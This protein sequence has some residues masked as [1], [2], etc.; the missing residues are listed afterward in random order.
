MFVGTWPLVRASWKHSRST[1]LSWASVVM[2]LSLLGVGFYDVLFPDP[3][4]VESMQGAVDTNPAL[5]LVMGPVGDLSSTDGLGAWLTVGLGAFF[6]GIG[7]ALLTV[8]SSRGQEDDGQAE[9]FAS[10]V[11]GRGARL[12]S[13]IVIGTGG[14]L[15]A[16]L[17]TAIVATVSGGTVETQLLVGA[18][19]TVT[20]WI[21]TA[22]AAVAAQLGSEK[23]TANTLALGVLSALYVLRGFCYSLDLPEWTIWAN[24]L[25]WMGQTEPVTDNIWWPLLLG[26]AFASLLVGIALFLQSRRDF[27]AGALAPKPGPNH[28]KI[29]G[30]GALTWRLNRSNVITWIGVLVVLGVMFGYF[31]AD[32]ADTLGKN[33]AVQQ[34]LASGTASQDDFN[35]QVLVTELTI[36]GV[37]A[38]IPGAQM[39]FKLRLEE[40]AYRIEPVLA[41][42]LSRLRLFSSSLALAMLSTALHLG[43]AGVLISLVSRASGTD[44][45]MRDV[46]AQTA[47]TLPAVWFFVA[48]AAFFVGVWPRGR[49]I[50]W[51]AIMASFL[52]TVLGP[53]LQ[54]SDWVLSWSPFHHVPSV[55][56]ADP[57]WTGLIILSAVDILLL[58]VSFIGYR[59]RDINA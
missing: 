32:A 28:G 19:V 36:L 59:R 18:I 37:V 23:Q 38:A 46:I 11:M 25:G 1:V 27:G 35:T 8:R 48:L 33:P 17:L 42:G 26:V 50:T 56:G 53:M 54:L 45:G 16:G 21:A 6:V 9:L 24:P 22:F 57:T 10:G 49:A 43:L 2:L 31:T 14:S 13:A 20:G 3:S 30:V 41:T 5:T 58:A 29:R 40:T 39:L 47:A 34:L 55:T 44:M 52:L 12:T 4:D 7:M 51:A 15:A